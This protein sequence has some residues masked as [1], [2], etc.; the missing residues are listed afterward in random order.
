[1]TNARLYVEKNGIV[2]DKRAG[3]HFS[4]GTNS[5]PWAAR[6]WRT[7]GPIDKRRI[8][9]AIKALARVCRITYLEAA[10]RHR[11]AQVQWFEVASKAKKN[12]RLTGRWKTKALHEA[13]IA[14][15]DEL[16]AEHS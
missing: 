6:E 10:E 5:L 2:P 12:D 4:D 8:D 7:L 15:V 14:L 16:I 11:A 13:H 1:M 9:R 3:L